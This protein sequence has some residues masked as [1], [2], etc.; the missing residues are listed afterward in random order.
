MSIRR[1]TSAALLIAVALTASAC[2]S[3]SS[4]PEDGGSDDVSKPVTITFWHAFKDDAHE[5]K[6][7]NEALDSFHRKF[8][9]ITVQAVKAQDDD[10]INQAIRGGTA[11]DVA[12]SFNAN[13]VGGWCS[14]GA[15]GDLGPLLAKD[16]Y[17]LGQIPKA[18]S[19]Y[20]EYRGKRCFMPWLADTFGL[21]YN[22]KLLAAAGLPGPPKTMTELA[23]YTKK[24]TKRG[25]DGTIQVAG[26]VPYLGVYQTVTEHLVPS[27]GGQW[28][29]PDGSSNVGA[30]PGFTQALTWQKSLVDW[31]GAAKLE[32]FKAGLGDEFSAQHGF[33]TGKIAMIVDGE[34]RTAFIKS[35]QATI[36]YATAPM[37]TA[38]DRT[39][40]YGAGFV[41]GNVIGI[42]RG[43]KHQAAAWQLVKF[44]TTDTDA[45]VSFANAIGNVPTTLDSLA[46]PKLTVSKDPN[47][48]TFLDVFKNPATSTTPAS[49]DGGAYLTNFGAF[50]QKW[51]TG[52]VPDLAKGLRELDKQNDAAL[53]LSR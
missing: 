42:P 2:T 25:A 6:A 31:Y 30:D 23:D 53:E 13:R 17:D 12:M 16:R 47:F 29:K 4:S 7:V 10:K 52:Q 34:W 50:A 33:E 14:S 35:D 26:F 48:V 44:L 19:Q 49:P 15:F 3:V 37:P 1:R 20:T 38:D 39:N 22:K 45:L 8:P 21:Y 51:Q 9:N 46:S 18:V 40:R 24:L 11:P 5:V 32:K 36:D 27:W 41:G 43:S 28:L